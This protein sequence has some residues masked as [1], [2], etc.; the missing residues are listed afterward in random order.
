MVIAS[1]SPFAGAAGV[2]IVMALEHLPDPHKEYYTC[3]PKE[4][5]YGWTCVKGLLPADKQVWVDICKYQP[6]SWHREA[7]ARKLKTQPEYVVILK[8]KES[9]EVMR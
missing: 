7:I 9:E 5:S 1:V 4:F 2:A 3:R 8:E 6:T